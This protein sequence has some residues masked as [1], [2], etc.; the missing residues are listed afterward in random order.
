MRSMRSIHY[1]TVNG[2]RLYVRALWGNTCA[3]F[4]YAFVEGRKPTDDEWVCSCVPVGEVGHRPA[5]AIDLI[6]AKDRNHSL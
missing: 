4:D 3:Y 2:Q 5:N 1:R 6:A